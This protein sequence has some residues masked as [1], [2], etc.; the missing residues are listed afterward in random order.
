MS[1]CDIPP[2]LDVKSAR[3]VADIFPRPVGDRGCF[4]PVCRFVMRGCFGPLGLFRPTASASNSFLTQAA[5]QVRPHEKTNSRAIGG[6]SGSGGLQRQRQ[7]PAATA[8][9]SGSARQRQRQRTAA[10]VA[11]R[12]RC[13][14]LPLPLRFLVAWASLGLNIR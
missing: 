13:R 11:V 5:K 8:A 12:C 4:G 6:G 14:S 10:A 9:T 1:W 3:A 7:R 2:R